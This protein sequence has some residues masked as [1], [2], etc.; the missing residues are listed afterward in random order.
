[1]VAEIMNNDNESD[2]ELNSMIAVE[3]VGR[4]NFE[5]MCQEYIDLGYLLSSTNSYV[6]PEHYN[7]QTKYIAIFAL[8]EV[9][10]NG[11]VCEGD[12]SDE[13]EEWKEGKEEG[14]KKQ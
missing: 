13:G 3:T 1:M 9:L 7:F 2:D 10:S 14:R 12:D 4:E 11:F 5:I 8:P 6:M